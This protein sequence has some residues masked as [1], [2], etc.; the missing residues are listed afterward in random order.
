MNNKGSGFAA[1]TF[2]HTKEGLKPIEARV[3]RNKP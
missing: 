3:G 2:V 1:G